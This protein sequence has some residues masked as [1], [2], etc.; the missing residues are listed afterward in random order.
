MQ[1]GHR[2]DAPALPV[3]SPDGL[4]SFQSSC[5]CSWPST[6]FFMLNTVESFPSPS[7]LLVDGDR[8]NDPLGLR[9]HQIDRQQPVLQ[10]GA[11][12]LHAVS[13]H[14]RALELARGNTAM[15]KLAALVVL[16]PTAD[17][18]LTFLDRDVEL[19]AGEAGNGERDT[20]P[21]RILPVAR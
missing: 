14:K 2:R 18:Q 8:S 19:V 11:E 5:R 1:V 21:L 15:E 9:P 7:V 10:V 3:W 6:P 17:H 20:Q 4:R 13:Q 16:L 12:H